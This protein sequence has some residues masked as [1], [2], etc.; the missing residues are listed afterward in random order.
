[1]S[2]LRQLKLLG[3]PILAVLLA[4]TLGA[5]TSP[6]TV[7]PTQ[8]TFNS[9]SGTAASQNLVIFSSGGP[10]AFTT[11][12]SSNGNWL[13]VTPQSGTT[14]QVL[15]VSV[16]PASL[17]NGSYGGFVTITA[18]TTSTVVPVILNVNTGGSSP[19]TSNPSSLSFNFQTNST[20]PQSQQLALNVTN[21]VSTSFT[22]TPSTSNGGAWLTVTPSASTAPGNLSVSVN[23]TNLTA[24]VYYGAIALN[25]PGTN[26]LVVPV[27]VNIAGPSTLNVSASS[28][29]FAYQTG[30]TAP[31]AQTLNLT[32]SGTTPVSFTASA[33]TTTCG[34]NWLVV[35]PQSSA[36]P[37]PLS[38]QINPTG[39]QPGNC[40]G[41]ITISAPGASNPTQTIPVNLLVSTNPLIQVPTNGVTLNYQL[42][43]APPASQTVQVTSSSTPLNFTVT[44]APLSGGPNFLTVTP[45]SGTTPQAIT[46]AVNPAVLSGLA[47]NTYAQNVTVTSAGAGNPAQTFTVTLNVSNNPMLVATQQSVAFNYQLGQTTPSNQTITLSS[48]GAPLSYAVTSATTTCPGFLT[49]TPATGTTQFQ[50]TQQSQIVVGVSTASITTPQTCTGTVT[51][52]V[53]GSTSAPL[54]LPV[55]LNASTTP[56]L[57]LSPA[58][59]NIIAT[60]ASGP[61]QQTISLTSTDVA[62]TLP[63]T[64]TAATNPAGLTWLSV[65]PNSGNS[66]ASLSVT[67]NPAGLPAGVYTGSIN[68]SS[69]AA[70]VAAQTIPV[71]LTVAS[72][73][74]TVTPATLTFNQAVG[75]A[76]PANQTITIA[77]VPTGTTV[78]ATTTLFNGSNW[79]NVA[80]SGNTITITP[81]GSQLTQGSY[82]GVITVFVPGAANS[83]IYIPVTYSVGTTAPGAYTL[84]PA[85]PA[86]FTYQSGGTLPAAQTFSVTGANGGGVAFNAVAVAPPGTAGGS[87]IVFLTVSPASGNTPGTLTVGL[88]QTTV[89]TL[90]PGT[91]TNT[92]NLTNPTAP[93]VVQ[94]IP[95]TLVVTSAG[96]PTIRTVQNGASFGSGAI[97]P[98]ELV[99]IF[100]S[101]IG[102]AVAVSTMLTSAGNVA[103]TLGN[104]TVTFNG[105][106][107]P[108]TY[109]S[110]NQINAVVPYSVAGAVNVSVVVTN[111]GTASAPIQV[112]V[113][114]T[115]PAIFTLTQNGLGQAAVVNQDGSVNG[116]SNA[117]ARGAVVAIYASGGGVLNPA[118]S[119]GSVTPTTGTS[120]PLNAA[121]ITVTIGGQPA[122]VQYAGAA[123]GLVSGV[124]QINVTV[125]QGTATGS[126]DV[127]ITSGG[128]SSPA[129][130][131]IAVK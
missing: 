31:A 121:P 78:G 96:V 124:L 92:V 85:T 93:G 87:G 11:N 102:P 23:P 51:V 76:V 104:V 125:P 34:S 99:S 75:G 127:V 117:V 26:G 69:T 130:V 122:T 86:S 91:Y 73:A 33:T 30:T 88:N 83:P 8:L 50:G 58:A 38:V 111:N 103:T 129:G 2:T 105:V 68:V 101:N 66:P 29:N 120:F 16:N 70:G 59:I 84:T 79:L 53:P 114:N 60:P 112:N 48:T 57:N 63:F 109:V 40:T 25:P 54:V 1:M 42:G 115:A 128:V 35:S 94:A 98:G 119:T 118:Q 71:T 107:A 41:S 20:V 56:L 18:G 13:T 82:S 116:T 24:G 61:M 46:L 80:T 72:A 39:L 74:V 19:L 45:S 15:A 43:T 49:V 28:V 77:G 6:L 3:L 123:P 95:F 131:T 7:S 89:A 44:T 100:G 65:A 14:P 47:P 55:T 81:A 113:A 4:G 126:Q 97:A 10:V 5:Q 90:A 22:V 106:P 9:T 108:L 37:A 27:Q 17:N 32:S 64:A 62:T 52:S 36:T 12:A 21:G 67:I 110:A